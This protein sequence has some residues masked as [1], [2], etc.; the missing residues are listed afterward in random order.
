[1]NINSTAFVMALHQKYG[2]PQM[3]LRRLALDEFEVGG[4]EEKAETL[5]D[6]LRRAGLSEAGI[7]EFRRRCEE[8]EHAEDD[9]NGPLGEAVSAL[10]QFVID[11]LQPED[12]QIGH[13][14]IGGLLREAGAAGEATDAIPSRGRNGLPRNALGGGGAMDEDR[15]RR[16]AAHRHTQNCDPT[17]GGGTS[18]YGVPT[19]RVRFPRERTANKGA[20]RY[21]PGLAHIK[22]GAI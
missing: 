7:S 22:L 20:E 14:L 8:G 3:V 6:F 15:G 5:A 17:L 18:A 16:V 10:Q 11:K 21:A 9:G 4:T 19:D 1:M 12:A 2:T 13:D